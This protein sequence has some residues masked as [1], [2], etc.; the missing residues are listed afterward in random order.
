M[1]DLSN[2]EFS[3]DR[4][5]ASSQTAQREVTVKRFKSAMKK[6]SSLGIKG[7]RFMKMEDGAGGAKMINLN[8][9][10][11]TIV[12][13]LAIGNHQKRKASFRRQGDSY[14]FQT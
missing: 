7:R 6:W 5:E 14:H 1:I 10:G 9:H 4:S 13:V 11:S 12:I 8:L 2:G 3:S